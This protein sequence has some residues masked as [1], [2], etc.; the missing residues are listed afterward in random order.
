MCDS[1]PADRRSLPS[2][3]TERRGISFSAV[4]VAEA[5]KNRNSE[6]PMILG[7]SNQRSPGG[8]RRFD[9]MKLGPDHG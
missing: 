6:N 8:D 5:R 4:T 7:S 9:S 2:A 1:D 3:S